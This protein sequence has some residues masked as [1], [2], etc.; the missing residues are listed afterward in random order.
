[1]LASSRDILIGNVCN[2]V[3]LNYDAKN[4]P[5]L[6]TMNED[7]IKAMSGYGSHVLPIPF[8][9]KNCRNAALIHHT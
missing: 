1:M 8:E 9:V 7:Q 4:F 2:I 5:P 6:K 3:I